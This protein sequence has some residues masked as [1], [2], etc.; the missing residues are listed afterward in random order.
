VYTSDDMPTHYAF[1][2][3]SS[4]PSLRTE[5]EKLMATD[6]AKLK[7]ARTPEKYELSPSLIANTRRAIDSLDPRGA[8][9]EPGRRRAPAQPE[10]TSRVI[11]TQTF[12]RNMDA[13]GRFIAASK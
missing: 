12:M 10:G 9:V 13:L 2:V 3:G 1:I 7:P 5:Y 6:A 4:V 8:W 11:T